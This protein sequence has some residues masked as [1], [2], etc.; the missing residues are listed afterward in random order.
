M[1]HLPLAGLLGLAA[2]GAKAQGIPLKT[3]AASEPIVV[4]ATREIAP[5][6]PTLLDSIVL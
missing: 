4:T 3:V 6:T 1:R 2:L 5:T